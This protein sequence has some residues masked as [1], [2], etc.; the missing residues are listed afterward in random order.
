[1]RVPAALGPGQEAHQFLRGSLRVAEEER[2]VFPPRAP[3]ACDELVPT[4]H[5][6]TRG[7]RRRAEDPNRYVPIWH[8]GTKLKG[9]T[10]TSQKNT[11]QGAMSKEHKCTF[12]LCAAIVS[13]FAEQ[14]G[15]EAVE[16]SSETET[17]LFLFEI[18]EDDPED[19][20]GLE[21]RQAELDSSQWMAEDD[22]HGGAL[23]AGLVLA[24]RQ[25]EI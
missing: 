8:D 12:H 19:D 9:R 14:M 5:S 10:D 13:V 15:L 22:V 11:R 16:S 23:P 4:G 2:K 1:M 7:L 3:L 25:K 24:A 6:E 17:P 21:L 20:Q 18:L